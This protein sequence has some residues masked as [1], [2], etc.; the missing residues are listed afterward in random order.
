MAH[1][2]YQSRGH[3]L[4]HELVSHEIDTSDNG[5]GPHSCCGWEARH[6]ATLVAINKSEMSG[7]DIKGG[8]RAAMSPACEDAVVSLLRSLRGDN[9]QMPTQHDREREHKRFL[10][11]IVEQ[12]E[13][14]KLHEKL[15]K[16]RDVSSS[17]STK[18]RAPNTS[19]VEAGDSQAVDGNAKVR[20]ELVEAALATAAKGSGKQK[21][22]GGKSSSDKKDKSSSKKKDPLDQYKL[23]TKKVMVLPR[24]MSI[25]QLLGQAKNKLRLKQKPV[26]CFCIAEKS[27]IEADLV[28]DL[29]GVSDGTTLY[30]SSSQSPSSQPDDKD[31]NN[32]NKGDTS[33]SD[34]ADIEDP[35]D[36][37][38]QTYIRQK[39]VQVERRRKS[40]RQG[41]STT[42]STR[43][44]RGSLQEHPQFSNFFDKL[45]PLTTP[46]SELPAA[47]CRKSFLTS[48]EQ[49]R[50]VI[51]C[52]STGC[53]KSSQLPQFLLDGMIA[54]NCH[55]QAHII[56]TQPRRVAA[57]S[58]A[59]RV[60]YEMNSSSPGQPG[61]TVGYQ[62]RLDRKIADDTA[63][64]VYCTVGI[65]LR[66]LVC[67]QQSEE[68][69]DE[70]DENDCPSAQDEEKIEKVSRTR[71]VP[72]NNVSH[73]VI[74][75]VS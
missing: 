30:V 4:S 9:T 62:V 52:G 27:K 12:Y 34:S 43:K 23:G 58:L 48:V 75:E 53:G 21:K 19:Q 25:D 66:M 64:I 59:H 32:D 31:G 28:G 57:T 10:K 39:Q 63:K 38:K 68:I 54:A 56:V 26:R 11:R 24:A 49:N 50:V 33:S 60:A 14:K 44:Q 17:D 5:V 16:Q 35:L 3:R 51:V 69:F 1:S 65:L 67:P 55:D 20:V 73:V 42:T 37:V 70:E 45:P 61:S 71:A 74:D 41:Q 72:L 13:R 15:N 46:R 2:T 29:Q 18:K 47:A 6:R 7:S 8:G 40:R 22:N 36:A